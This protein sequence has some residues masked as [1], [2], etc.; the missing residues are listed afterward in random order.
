MEI[1]PAEYK[2]L[3]LNLICAN[4]EHNYAVKDISWGNLRALKR[5]EKLGQNL[6]ATPECAQTTITLIKDA[7]FFPVIKCNVICAI[8][9]QIPGFT[10]A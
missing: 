6:R 4:Q 2:R 1:E 10:M 3:G 9:K 5:Q 7:A 8:M